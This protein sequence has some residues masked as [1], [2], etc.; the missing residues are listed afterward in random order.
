MLTEEVA[1]GFAT[2]AQRLRDRGHERHGVAHFVIRCAFCMF[3]ENA[4]LLPSD[5]FTSLLAICRSAKTDCRLIIQ[6]VV[7]GRRLDSEG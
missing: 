7:V 2:L 4:K 5:I 1:S 6:S 3:A